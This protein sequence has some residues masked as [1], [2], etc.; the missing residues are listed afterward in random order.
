MAQVNR[1]LKFLYLAL[2]LSFWCYLLYNGLHDITGKIRFYNISDYIGLCY[3]FIVT[4]YTIR[5]FWKLNLDIGD[6]IL[7]DFV[8]VALLF[9]LW[10]IAFVMSDI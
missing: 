8:L 2:V 3:V 10:I 9:S 4:G 6:N 7:I 5:R 1:V